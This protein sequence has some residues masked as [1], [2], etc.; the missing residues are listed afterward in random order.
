M[1]WYTHYIIQWLRWMH[2]R[3]SPE[4]FTPSM[5]YLRDSRWSA[6]ANPP[7]YFPCQNPMTCC[8]SIFVCT[9]SRT[10]GQNGAQHASM[11]YWLSVHVWPKFIIR[12]RKLN[13]TPNWPNI[14]APMTLFRRNWTPWGSGRKDKDGAFQNSGSLGFFR[15]LRCENVCLIAEIYSPIGRSV[16]RRWLV[17][18]SIVPLVY[19]TMPTGWSVVSQVYLE[20]LLNFSNK[21]YK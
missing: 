14:R 5:Q 15:W 8:S 17:K 7:H 18:F 13:K 1:A 3:V 6:V 11:A 20:Q 12:D 4:A 16:Q 19:R 2:F 10:R 21:T 9:A